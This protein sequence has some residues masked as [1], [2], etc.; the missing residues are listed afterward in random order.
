M[1]SSRAP[2]YAAILISLTAPVSLGRRAANAAVPLHATLRLAADSSQSVRLDLPV[3]RPTSP[4]LSIAAYPQF[5]RISDFCL[6]NVARAL[7][8]SAGGS[9]MGPLNNH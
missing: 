8:F 6:W 9:A 5:P 2:R 1:I 7:K 3:S 4:R